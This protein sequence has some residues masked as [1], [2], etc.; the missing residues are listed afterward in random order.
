V[1]AIID[2]GVG[3]LRSITKSVEILGG[4]PVITTDKRVVAEADGIILPGVGAF[5][6]AIKMLKDS[7]LFKVIK[8]FVA[9]DKP[10]LGICLGMQLFFSKSTE[11]GNTKGMN[12]IKGTVEKLPNTEKL[13]QMGWNN[14]SFQISNLK[15]QIFRDVKNKSYF[16][17]VHSYYCNPIDKKTIIATTDYAQV[18]PSIIQNG[19]IFGTQFHPEKSSEQGLQLLK[20]FVEITKS[21]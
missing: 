16:Y 2:Y 10:I 4:N 15:S 19:N 17:F 7:G 8:N 14:V 3:N 13:P 18:F 12:L 9:K 20:N 11:G 1:I 21:T 5:K 6:P